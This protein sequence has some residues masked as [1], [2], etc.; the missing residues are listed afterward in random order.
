MFI[1]HL[2]WLRFIVDLTHRGDNRLVADW[3]VFNSNPLLLLVTCTWNDSSVGHIGCCLVGWV[4]LGVVL[5][6][7]GVERRITIVGKL[8]A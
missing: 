3:T 8:D 5:G 2:R 4:G 7:V 6:L 1:V